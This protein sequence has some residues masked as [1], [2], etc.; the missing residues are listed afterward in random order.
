MIANLCD[1]LLNPRLKNSETSISFEVDSN[2]F[3]FNIHNG[4]GGN[5]S[6]SMWKE[7]DWQSI[8]VSS[9]DDN[10][11]KMVYFTSSRIGMYKIRFYIYDKTFP[12]FKHYLTNGT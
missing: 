6:A 5:F 9:L 11:K 10:N 4:T 12:E 7:E 2:Y 1:S 3:L 8:P